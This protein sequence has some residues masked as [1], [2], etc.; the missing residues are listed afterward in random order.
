MKTCLIWIL[1]RSFRS[2]LASAGLV[3]GR[4]FV[5]FASVVQAREA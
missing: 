1:D 2:L 5:D 4:N 3:L